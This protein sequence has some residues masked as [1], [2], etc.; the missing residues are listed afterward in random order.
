MQFA[1]VN[2]S[3]RMIKI[4]GRS[5]AWSFI[6][7]AIALMALRRGISLSHILTSSSAELRTCR[8]N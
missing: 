1:A 6:A 3:L 2:F 4:T 5:L 7:G 8:W